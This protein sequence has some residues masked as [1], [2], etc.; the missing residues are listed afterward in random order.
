MGIMQKLFVFHKIW[1]HIFSIDVTDDEACFTVIG[2]I[3]LQGLRLLKPTIGETFVV[4]GLGLI[5]LLTAQLLLANGCIVIGIDLDDSKL[6]LASKWGVI[7]FNSKRGD[8]VK[9][10]ESTTKNIGADGIIITAS[11]SGNQIIS[12]SAKMSRKRGRIVLIGV[13]GLE[14]TRSEFY[15]KELSFQVSCSYGPGRYDENYE[16]KGNDYPLPYVRWSAKRNFETIL[17]SISNSNLHVKE[18]ISEIIQF[19][20]YEK[21]YNS[22]S[23]S[24]SIASI[25]SYPESKGT[26]LSTNIKLNDNTFSAAKGVLGIIGAGNF[27]K[28]TMLPTLKNFRVGLKYIASSG[29]ITGTALAKKYNFSF[30]TTDYKEILSDPEVDLVLI[31]TRHDRH[32]E[33]VVE[34]LENNKNVF[35]EK[36]LAL[37]A[38]QLR[39][40]IDAYNTSNGK[41]LTVGFNRRFSPI[42]IRRKV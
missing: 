40:I 20:D 18:L 28:M 31:T 3:G 22:I 32:A 36:P 29:G 35:V 10:V 30:S 38:S 39:T 37:N 19:K 11:A 27:T 25:L 21:I 16:Q 17:G 41:T 34:C 12:Q 8:V 42:Q 15:E 4:V 14:L 6:S 24:K 2:S 26:N 7:P 5:G 13:V 1:L 23:S 9:F 33:L